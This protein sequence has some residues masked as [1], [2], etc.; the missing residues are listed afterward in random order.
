MT[1]PGRDRPASHTHPE[2]HS[3]RASPG[4]SLTP[5]TIAH[6][7]PARSQARAKECDSQSP[8]SAP[9]ALCSF[10]FERGPPTI[11]PIPTTVTG[12]LSPGAT[13]GAA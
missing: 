8:S 2:A 10:C 7:R 1:R 9:V 4:P 5:R 3:G 13:R 11:E 6:A 12:A